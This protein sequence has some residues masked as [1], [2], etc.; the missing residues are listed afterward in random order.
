VV[1]EVTS[2]HLNGGS[3]N[4]WMLAGRHVDSLRTTN[5]PLNTPV[6]MGIVYPAGSATGANGAFSSLHPGGG[7]FGF[8]DG[9]VSFISETIDLATYRA[10]STREGGESV[11]LP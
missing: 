10:L 4:R 8:G 11:S 1:G 7:M 5:N 3:Y 2:A 9:S 6:N